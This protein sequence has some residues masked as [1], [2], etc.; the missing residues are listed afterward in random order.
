MQ[1]ND[2]SRFFFCFF[3][4]ILG[5]T[6]ILPSFIHRAT[7]TINFP[8]ISALICEN[9]FFELG[10]VF[11][12]SK[13]GIFCDKGHDLVHI[14]LCH[15]C[16]LFVLTLVI[17]HTPEQMITHFLKIIASYYNRYSKFAAALA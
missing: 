13:V 9:P 3:W 11:F 5:W 12:S 10:G 1:N 2:V 6:I 7:L 16:Q 8:K 17:Y 4:Y 14:T 15:Q